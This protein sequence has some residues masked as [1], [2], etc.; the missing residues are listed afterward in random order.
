MSGALLRAVLRRRPARIRYVSPVPDQA[1]YR[2]VEREF[3]LVA[4]PI[5]LHS[6]HPL[7]LAAGW[8][9]LRESLVVTTSASR[10]D[11]EVVAAAVS[12]GNA[13]PYCVA[14][15][16]AT[17]HGLAPDG[18]G[19]L[20]AA[21][22]LERIQDAEVRRLAG[23]AHDT[24]RRELARPA[25][26]PDHAAVAVVFHYINRMVTVFL[27]DSPVPAQVPARV[28][29]LVLRTLGRFL[30]PAALARHAPG[31]SLSLL[32]PA[33]PPADL[34]WAEGSPVLTDAFSRVYAA[35]DEIGRQSVPESVRALVEAELAAWDG[36]PRGISRGW[37]DT[38][39]LDCPD[40]DRAAGRLALLVALAPYQVDEQVVAEFRRTDPRDATLVGLASWSSLT[41]ARRVGSWLGRPT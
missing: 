28:R 26:L 3:G 16:S 14:V 29:P 5:T 41:A 36:R 30:R 32:P 21:G 25:A 17:L 9:M 8:V 40:A 6:P 12:L 15:H 39:L 38:A 33:P 7:A 37:V 11:K 1:V 27:D 35:G 22:R 34:G 4:P 18:V 20:L 10:R 24:G 31:T 2:E 13:C 23:W 19:R